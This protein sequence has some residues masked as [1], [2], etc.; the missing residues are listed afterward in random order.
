MLLRG[1]TESAK[2][3]A[4]VRHHPVSGRLA[5]DYVI[6]LAAC[7]DVNMQKYLLAILTV[8]KDNTWHVR[9]SVSADE[10]TTDFSALSQAIRAYDGVGK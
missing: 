3:A 7:A 1:T 8:D 6:S 2:E 4:R 10:Q 5:G 9:F